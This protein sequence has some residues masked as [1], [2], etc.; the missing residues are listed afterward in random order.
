MVREQ[1]AIEHRANV[2]L[3][4]TDGVV[5][6]GLAALRRDV[7]AGIVHENVDRPEFFRRGLDHARDVSTI[8]EIAEHPNGADAMRRRHSFRDRRQR[9][10]LA[11]F[12]GAIFTHAVYGDVGTE[13]REPLGERPAKPSARAGD[14]R[15]LAFQRPGGVLY[16]HMSSPEQAL[17]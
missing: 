14:Q 8:G 16:R 15:N 3:A 10:S 13:A 17:Q 7:A 6:I 11:I 1:I 2:L 4:D 12:G 9:R 5:R